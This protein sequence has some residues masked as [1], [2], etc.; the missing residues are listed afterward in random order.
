MIEILTVNWMAFTAAIS[1]GVVLIFALWFERRAHPRLIALLGMLTALTVVSRQLMH[2]LGEFSPVFTLVI[3]VGYV[4]GSVSGFMVGA[5]TILVSNFL[6]GHGPWTPY[7]MI[8][9]GVVGVLAGLIPKMRRGTG[10]LLTIYGMF[11]GYL[12]G[13]IT[14]VFWW[15]AFAA[16]RTLQTYLAVASAGLLMDTSR[17]L[18][19]ALFML[20]LGPV[21]VK[22]LKRFQKRFSVRV[23]REKA[24]AEN[25]SSKRY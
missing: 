24:G 17:A 13:L 21:L 9:L 6:L 22:T 25:E 18:G 2:S 14:D 20:L 19:N 12:Y 3:V 15:S 16:E 7:Q 11:S 8:G 10:I 1:V 23:I 5:A 4:F